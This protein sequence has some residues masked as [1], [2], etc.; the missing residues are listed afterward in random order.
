MRILLSTF[1]YLWSTTTVFLHL[2]LMRPILTRSWRISSGFKPSPWSLDFATIFRLRWIK[3]WRLHSWL[4][5]NTNS[6][7]PCA[8]VFPSQ[9]NK[10]SKPSKTP[11]SSTAS[12][13]YS[14]STNKT[15]SFTCLSKKAFFTSSS[16]KEKSMNST[17][18]TCSA[19]L[20]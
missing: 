8:T 2:T 17:N 14:S 16:A 5:T 15:T 12:S 9:A 18:A 11:N 6:W 1:S 13:P 19:K 7:K 20:I 4:F 3:L 10:F